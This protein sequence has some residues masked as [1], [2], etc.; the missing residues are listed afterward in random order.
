M[1][2][3]ILT[4]FMLACIW[5]MIGGRRAFRNPWVYGSLLL[6]LVGSAGLLGL[7][8]LLRDSSHE[9]SDWL[10]D[11]SFAL[12]LCGTGWAWAAG[13]RRVEAVNKLLGDAAPDD[14]NTKPYDA[15]ADEMAV[16]MGPERLAALHSLI[17]PLGGAPGYEW[18]TPEWVDARLER[19]SGPLPAARHEL[20]DG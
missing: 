18:L 11:F 5:H 4:L 1:K 9:L 17:A 12:L 14:A 16:H 10:G 13:M 2:Y 20:R 3:I 19:L 8:S 6:G 7:S 15:E